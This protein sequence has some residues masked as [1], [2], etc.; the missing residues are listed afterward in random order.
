MFVFKYAYLK[1]FDKFGQKI[2]DIVNLFFGTYFNTPCEVKNRKVCHN[3]IMLKNYLNF[4][5]CIFFFGPPCISTFA[6]K[7]FKFWCICIY[8]NYISFLQFFTVFIL[9]LVIQLV[10]LLFFTFRGTNHDLC[11]VFLTLSDLAEL[12]L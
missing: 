4:S 5:N 11:L 1:W 7:M 2:L 8:L 3:T 6:D 9:K 12:Q 10:L